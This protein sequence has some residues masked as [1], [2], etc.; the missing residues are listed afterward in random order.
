LPQTTASTPENNNNNNT[1]EQQQQQLAIRK[2]TTTTT[3][4]T[5]NIRQPLAATPAMGLH[6]FDVLMESLQKKKKRHNAVIP[7]FA[8]ELENAATLECPLFVTW[9]SQRFDGWQLRGCIGTLSPRLLVP[10]VSDYALLS[11]LKDRRFNPIQ[12]PEVSSLRVAVS[13]LVQYEVCQ[14]VHD[15]TVGVH[16]ILIKFESRGQHYSATYLPEVANDQGW[17]QSKAVQSLIQKSGY[18]GAVTPEL[19][20]TIHCT[21]YQSSKCRVTFGEYVL[22]KQQHLTTSSSVAAAADD[23]PSLEEVTAKA[24]SRWSPCNNL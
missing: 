1:K 16:G 24:S 6:C 19:L 23:D 11:A 4:T 2:T 18:R 14:D 20:G 8:K 22:H 3:T 9:E 17:N 12:L 7:E 15:W 5:T 10:S 13:L 21:R